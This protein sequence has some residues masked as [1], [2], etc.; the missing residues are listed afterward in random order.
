MSKL[1]WLVAGGVG[2]LLGSRA[3]REPY[4]KFSEQA[5]RLMQDPRVQK[6]ADQAKQTVKRKADE[7][8][9]TVMNGD[10]GGS[11]ALRT[12]GQVP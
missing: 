1:T 11:D 2:Y 5:Q 9:D 12:P 6:G 10:G 8:A 4:E 7:V 3:G